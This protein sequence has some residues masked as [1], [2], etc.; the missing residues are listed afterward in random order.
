MRGV[1]LIGALVVAGSLAMAAPVSAQRVV[2]IEDRTSVP[3]FVLRALSVERTALDREG[4]ALTVPRDAVERLAAVEEMLGRAREALEELDEGLALRA[5]VEAERVVAASLHVP[6]ASRYAAEVALLE[7]EVFVQRGD[8]EHAGMR[9]E[10]AL[11]L[12]P[13]RVLRPADASPPLVELAR[14]FAAREAPTGRVAV[15]ALRGVRVYIDDVELDD[16]EL[17]RVNE[18]GVLEERDAHARVVRAGPHVVRAS[19][20]GTILAFMIDVPTG[21]AGRIDLAAIS[22]AAAAERVRRLRACAEGECPTDAPPRLLVARGERWFLWDGGS[23][24]E[25]EPPIAGAA[26]GP[27]RPVPHEGPVVDEAVLWGAGIGV[28]A[29]GAG[30]LAIVLATSPS[31]SLA[32]DTCLTCP[33]P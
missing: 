5:L 26:R 8:L 23:S 15:R 6:G 32:V 14:S 1:V 18:H 24:R 11:S 21:H 33:L 29:V 3:D 22:R 2:T 7:A 27:E 30:V 28:V 10:R 12:D 16:A 4:P 31:P 19:L 13:R 9:V 20:A 25:I 17:E